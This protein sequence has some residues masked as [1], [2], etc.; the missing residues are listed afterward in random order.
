MYKIINLKLKK[1]KN[2]KKFPKHIINIMFCF[3]VYIISLSTVK[4]LVHS[5]L[6]FDICHF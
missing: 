3:S 6:L 5:L 2:T 4:A 1:K